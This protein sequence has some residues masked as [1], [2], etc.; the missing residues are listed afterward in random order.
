MYYTYTHSTPE[1]DVFYV[2]KGKG[3][4]VYSM[5]DRH[6]LWRERLKV[7]GGITMKIVNR[8][9]TEEEAFEDEKRL[10][11]EYK[12]AGCDL[13][14]LSD[15]GN[16]PNG[17][18]QSPETIAKKSKAMRGYKYDVLTC[19]HCGTQGG[20]TSIKRWHFDNCSGV[21]PQHKIRTTVFGDRIYLGKA[22]TKAEADA[23]ANEFKDLVMLEA[24][25][26][27]NISIQEVAA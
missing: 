9:E 27:N 16:G 1:G 12:D 2:G 17:A 20:A 11:A 13:V 22:H 5:S 18:K 24:S 26:M 6:Y 3:Q 14:N 4:R 7:A 19:P 10:I 15:G 21:R 23:I 8:F 25:N